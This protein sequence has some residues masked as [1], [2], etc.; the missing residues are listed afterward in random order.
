MLKEYVLAS[1]RIELGIIPEFGCHWTFLK[2]RVRG[3]WQDLLYPVPRS[4]W[5]DPKKWGRY[6]NYLLAPWSNRVKKGIFRFRGR[7][8][9]LR[10]NMPDKTAIHGDVMTRPWKVLSVDS[11]AIE[12]ELDSVH[13]PDFNFPFRF[14][15]RL[16]LRV[17]DSRVT[18]GA[19]VTNRDAQDAPAGLGFHP[20]FKR[21]LTSADGDVVLGIP[22]EKVYPA[23]R[24]IPLA[25]AVPVTGLRDL[26]ET[27]R[28]GKRGLD[29]CYTDR[30]PAPVRFLY[31]GSR[32][33]VEMRMDPVF[34]HIVVYA[35]D[36]WRGWGPPR[37]FFCVEPV[38]HANDGF[39]LLER[40]WEK[41]GVK[42][43]SPGETWGG[44][45]EMSISQG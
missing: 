25:P 41:T 2:V 7:E 15:Y 13:F 16:S 12:A 19:W 22:A 18:A 31:P 35:P 37:P 8:Y 5:P 26:R 3:S 45:F 21:R 9:R 36:T 39:N 40:G 44:S 24:C 30:G 11:N 42:V 32:V 10:M 34:S 17:E 27:A 38:T 4:P 14:H 20:Y 6:G 33:S 43:L 23:R 1:D 28:L 29:D